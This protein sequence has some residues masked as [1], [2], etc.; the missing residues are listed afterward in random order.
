[1]AP[2]EILAHQHYQLAKKLF[3]K[4][5][6]NLKIITGKTDFKEKKETVSMLKNGKINFLFGTHSLFQNKIKFSNLGLIIIDEQHKFGVNQRLKLAK[7]GGKNCDL[8]LISATPI[9]RTM[10]L[11]FFAN[12]SL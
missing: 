3:K 5:N 4:T 10:M 11:S 9:P 1:M 7:K 8:L 12:L 6:V 2:T